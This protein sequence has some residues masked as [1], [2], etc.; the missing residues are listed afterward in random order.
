MLAR[1]DVKIGCDPRLEKYSK[2]SRLQLAARETLGQ[3]DHGIF[4]SKKLGNV[5]EQQTIEIN[6]ARRILRDC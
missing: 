5:V 3:L 1:D 6:R 4:K 2:A